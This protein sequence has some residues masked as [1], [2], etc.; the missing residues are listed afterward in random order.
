M[1][2]PPP[3]AHVTG[4]VEP[5]ECFGGF[6]PVDAFLW[7]GA[8]VGRCGARPGVRADG[9]APEC[10]GCAR[11]RHGITHAGGA[12]GRI[13]PVPARILPGELDEPRREPMPPTRPDVPKIYDITVLRP[14]VEVS[15]GDPSLPRAVRALCGA[16]STARVFAA[17]ISRQGVVSASL[18]V[19]V[20]GVGHGIYERPEGGSW[21][22]SRGVLDRPHLRRCNAGQFAAAVAGAEYVPPAPREPAPKGSCPACG[23]EVSL[24][25]AGAVFKSHKCGTKTVEGRS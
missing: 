5:G 8:C 14:A 6:G 2:R 22:W 13:T 25:K 16:A 18:A 7:R 21:E 1:T 11:A 12:I 17:V 9:P 4:T 19:R 20:P 10:S 23:A 3:L 15:T 24:T